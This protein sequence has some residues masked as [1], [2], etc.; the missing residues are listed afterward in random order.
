MAKK[1]KEKIKDPLKRIAAVRKKL[2]DS[3]TDRDDHIKEVDE[4]TVR[5][6]RALI[7]LNLQGHEGIQMITARAK[8]EMTDILKVLKTKRPKD[9]SP[10]GSVAYSMEVKDMFNRLDLWEWFHNLF[11]EAEDEIRIITANL[12]EQEQTDE[13]GELHQTEY[14]GDK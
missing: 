14:V 4:W 10:D 11:V 9:L 13:E 5:A 8:Q 12:D 2:V 7:I 1:P 3:G 6:K